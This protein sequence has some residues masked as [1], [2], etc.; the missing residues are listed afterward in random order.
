MSLDQ[1]PTFDKSFCPRFNNSKYNSKNRKLLLFIFERT[2]ILRL[3]L[4]GSSITALIDTGATPSLLNTDCANRLQLS[5]TPIR[6]TAELG[7]KHAEMTVVGTAQARIQI[8][9]K[10]HTIT[11]YVAPTR[12]DCSLSYYD[13]G[14]LN[15]VADI[16][17][18]TIGYGWYLPNPSL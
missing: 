18:W 16:T 5:I 2:P 15:I 14:L 13:L 12:A 4:N 9:H 10:Q 8:L 7:A 3:K 17:L 6:C 1:D 11:F